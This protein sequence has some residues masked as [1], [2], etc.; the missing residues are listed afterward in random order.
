MS[1]RTTR[2]QSTG[3][4]ALMRHS[5]VFVALPSFLVFLASFATT[6]VMGRSSD[7]TEAVS[8]ILPPV[9]VAAPTRKPARKLQSSTRRA[10]SPAHVARAGSSQTPPLTPAAGGPAHDAAPTPLNSNA[11]APGA[12]RLGLTVRETPATV[13]VIDQ[14]TIRDQ[15]YRTVTDVAQGAVGVTAG[16][17]PGEPS[18]FSMRGF[19]NS[20]LN[21]LYN[22]IKIGP[23]NMTSR[24]MDTA[25][26]E[27]VEILKGPASLLS[28]EGASGGAVNFVNKQPTS[29][30]VRNEAFFS[31][32]SLNSYRSSYGSGG[33]T[34][35]QGLDY[36]FDISRSSLTGFID[37][38]NT[39]TSN[40]SGQLNY[41]VSENLGCDRVQT[42]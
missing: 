6:P 2:Q 12:S 41:K 32:D 28:G 31:F 26:L 21:V 38:T 40:A 10:N 39:R 5:P 3:V 42:G 16:D 22:G 34:N 27:S 17:G 24:Y 4:A 15:G 9:V 30:P 1:T 23:Q 29:G 25:N 35:V 8:G 18:A 33:S 36:R 11:V 14:K 7:S 37:D 13:D 20:Q 19:S